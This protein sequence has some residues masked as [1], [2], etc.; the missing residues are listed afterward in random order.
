VEL[1][2]FLLEDEDGDIV[3]EAAP[4][5]GNVPNPDSEN[6]K[7]LIDSTSLADGDMNPD[8]ANLNT[9]LLTA[10]SQV[11]I[12]I[13]S[14]MSESNL[15]VEVPDG[16]AAVALSSSKLRVLRP[17]K[18]EAK[19]AVAKKQKA[20]KKKTKKVANDSNISDHSTKAVKGSNFSEPIEADDVSVK[21]V[22]SRIFQ[23]NET[24]SGKEKLAS[25]LKCEFVE[26]NSEGNSSVAFYV[27]KDHEILYSDLSRF[28]S[29]LYISAGMINAFFSLMD[30]TFLGDAKASINASQSNMRSVR[31]GESSLWTHYIS[32][33]YYPSDKLKKLLHFKSCKQFFFPINVKNN[34]WILAC[35]DWEKN[36]IDIYDPLDKTYP[37]EMMI[38]LKRINA[39]L[40]NSHSMGTNHHFKENIQRQF[41]GHSCAFFVCWYAHQ[42]AAERSISV[43]MEK[44]WSTEIETISENVVIS[45][46]EKKIML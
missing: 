12:T 44:Q 22:L 16:S 4:L 36:L 9:N 2:D 24:M 41:D 17:R 35:I 14:L 18:V 10:E 5:S 37:A 46:I 1:E 29:K 6:H 32:N 33:E 43:W 45:L 13:N 26:R 21:D 15:S 27:D 40:G 23:F 7:V 19:V 34:H 11:E 38:L 8:S 39:L 28:K 20:G 31:F 42:L 30:A 25:I 3:E